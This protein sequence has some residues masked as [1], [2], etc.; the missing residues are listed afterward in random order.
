[1]IH[2]ATIDIKQLGHFSNCDQ[3]TQDCFPLE[4]LIYTRFIECPSDDPGFLAVKDFSLYNGDA[5]SEAKVPAYD[6]IR[7]GSV[8]CQPDHTINIGANVCGTA[9]SVSV[10]MSGPDQD[11]GFPWAQLPTN[12]TERKAPYMVLGKIPLCFKLFP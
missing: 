3:G 2:K 9:G 1:M 7:D 12:R 11:L 10:L 8:I 4:D 6:P 5:S